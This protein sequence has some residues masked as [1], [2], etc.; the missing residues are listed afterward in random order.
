MVNGW[1]LETGACALSVTVTLNAK[2]EPLALVGVP[3][4][5]P[6]FPSVSPGGKAPAVMLQ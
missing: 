3:L 2:G 4:R 5:E 6:S 1:E